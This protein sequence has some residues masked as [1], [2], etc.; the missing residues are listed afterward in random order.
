M[1]IYIVSRLILSLVFWLMM[2][3]SNKKLKLLYFDPIKLQ[4]LKKW[5]CSNRYSYGLK[6][7][8]IRCEPINF[9]YTFAVGY[10]H[11]VG[12]SI[13]HDQRPLIYRL[14]NH[15]FGFIARLVIYFIMLN[16]EGASALI[17]IILELFSTFVILSTEYTASKN[18]IVLLK[19]HGATRIEEVKRNYLYSLLT[20]I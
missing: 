17:I 7:R 9:N 8:I 5:K 18:A 3:R 6:S 1:I 13:D 15:S 11:E 19:E 4:E 2:E 20:Y 16:V 14:R 10:A 12:H